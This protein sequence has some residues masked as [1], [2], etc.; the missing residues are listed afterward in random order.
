MGGYPL[1]EDLR[2][3]LLEAPGRELGVGDH[4]RDGDHGAVVV[5]LERAER[6]DDVL[7]FL[8]AVKARTCVALVLMLLS[9]NM[10]WA[11]RILKDVVG[12]MQSNSATA[13]VRGAG[14][15]DDAGLPPTGPRPDKTL[16]SATARSSVNAVSE[17]C[18]SKCACTRA[19][20]IRSN[21]IAQRVPEAGH[22]CRMT[23]RIGKTCSETE[24]PKMTSEWE[25]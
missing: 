13:G 14:I 21:D 4:L 12:H 6:L 7:R 24:P 1:L 2:S 22:P 15:P 20:T 19:R 8:Y 16:T 9:Q 10:A 23:R 3:Q 18:G 25:P 17:P 11:R 5:P